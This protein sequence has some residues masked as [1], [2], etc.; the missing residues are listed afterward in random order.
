MATP[1]YLIVNADDFGLSAGVN[2]GIIHAHE[3]GIV[4]SASL[5]VYGPAAGEAAAYSRR[6][7]AFSIGLHVDLCEWTYQNSTWVPVYERVALTDRHAVAQEVSHQLSAFQ[8]LLSKNPSHL[9]SH[10][11]VHRQ[12]SVRP[13]LV[14]LARRL[15]I[16]LRQESPLVH[17]CG[18]FYGQTGEG[19]PL[20]DVISPAGLCKILAALPAGLSELSCHP[21]EG[22]DLQTMYRMERAQEVA[23]LCDPRIRTAL[24]AESIELRSFADIAGIPGLFGVTQE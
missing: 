8:R 4:T 15:G 5:M 24:V 10:Q 18:A 17:Y 7:L 6:R 12:E 19:V 14:Q 1:R 3:H 11:Y 13:V 23:V 9:D 21:G 20:P 2:G 22:E 16:P